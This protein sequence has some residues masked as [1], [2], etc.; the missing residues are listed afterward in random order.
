MHLEQKQMFF[1]AS[2]FLIRKTRYKNVVKLQFKSHHWFATEGLPYFVDYKEMKSSMCQNGTKRM[3][4]NTC[5]ITSVLIRGN[6]N[7]CYT[8]LFRR[9]FWMWNVK[10]VAAAATWPAKRCKCEISSEI[11]GI[12]I[13]FIMH[14]IVKCDESNWKWPTF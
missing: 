2:N 4:L 13:R 5:S 8:F 9:W 7:T 12:R 11:Y 6:I 10:I 1:A 14:L 3:Q